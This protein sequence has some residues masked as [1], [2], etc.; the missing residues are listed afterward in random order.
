MSDDPF[1]EPVSLSDASPAWARQ[2]AEEARRIGD[3]LGRMAVAVEHIGSTSVPLRGKPIIDVQLAVEASSRAQAI[4]AL[5][6]LGYR[7]H[8]E[9]AVPGRSYLTRRATDAPDVNVHVVPSESPVL[10]DN[11]MIRD[12]LRADPEAAAEYVRAK[13]RAL[14]HGYS[15]LRTYSRA[16]DS[17]LA[18]IREAARTWA[19]PSQRRTR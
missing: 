5:E 8:V 11:R 16:K 10:E 15:D 12:Y 14:A 18:A 9:G 2:Y 7:H 19:R 13:E 1:L 3:A 4:A 17:Q 6:R